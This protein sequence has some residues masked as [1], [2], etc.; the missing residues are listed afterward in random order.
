MIFCLPFKLGIKDN[1]LLELGLR[2]DN[3]IIYSNLMVNENRLLTLE[4]SLGHEALH[5]TLAKIDSEL[6]ISLDSLDT[7]LFEHNRRM[8]RALR[9]V[10]WR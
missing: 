5:E 7:W 8:W 2:D 6:T 4:H 9:A 10:D 1:C 3:S